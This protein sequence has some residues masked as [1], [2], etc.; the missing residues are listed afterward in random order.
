MNLRKNRPVVARGLVLAA[1]VLIGASL[2]C[3]M[4]GGG[5]G[6]T[7]GTS[8]T[9]AKKGLAPKEICALLD[10]PLFET[11]SP[12]DG[13]G[14]SGGTSF[15]VRDTRTGSYETDT[16][17]HYSLA[18]TGDAD[19]VNRVM[20]LLTRRDDVAARQMYVTTADTIARMINNQPLPTEIESAITG[21]PGDFNRTWQ[22]GNAKVELDRTSAENKF[23]LTFQ[24]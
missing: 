18:A 14:C 6:N 19:E 2:G 23:Y 12:Y 15:G 9:K 7:N 4:L 22:I 1:V 5:A 20:L 8:D 3:K 16:R 10:D 11:R 24:F 13:S 17:P 21:P